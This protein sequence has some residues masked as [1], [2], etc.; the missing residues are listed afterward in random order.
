MDKMLYVA[1]SGAKE[2]FNGIAIRGNN[3]ANASTVGFKADLENAR[4]MSVI[5]EGFQ[6]RTFAMTERP[7]SNLESGALTTTGRDLDVSIHGDG[8]IAVQDSEGK[9]AYSRNGSLS[10]DVDGVLRNSSGQAIL[11]DAGQEIVLPIPLEK[12]SINKDGVISG[13][14]EGV[15]P[16]IIEEFDQ[17]KLVKIPA[18]NTEKGIDGLFRSK[19]FNTLT[20]MKEDAD[21]TV[22]LVN[23]T[24]ESSNVNVVEEMTNLIR[25]Q[26]KFDMQLKMMETAKE[27]D[28]SQ[29]NLLRFS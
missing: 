20:Y 7:S 21:P 22:E 4:S 1:M 25:L 11:N 2:C 29:T 26:R 28:E 24:I 14:P 5:G 23:G 8:Y 6:T 12:I 16:N 10:I 27:M 18:A 3:L 19:D 17:I 13:R 15:A 9:E